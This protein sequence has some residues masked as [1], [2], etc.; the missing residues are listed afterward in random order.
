MPLRDEIFARLEQV[1]F[2]GFRYGIVR[3]GL[4]RDVRVEAG[5]VV[6]ELIAASRRREVAQAIAQRVQEAVATIPQVRSVRVA[7]AGDAAP[8][9]H[10]HAEGRADVPGVRRILAVSS[11]KGG[12]GKSTVAVNLAVSLRQAGAKVALMDADVYGPSAPL[13][14]GIDARPRPVGGKIAPIERYGIDVMSM[15]FFLDDSSPVIWRGPMV[16][17]LI[18]QFLRDIEWGEQDYLVVDMP[19]GTGDAA[20]TLA[21]QVPLAGAV[22]VTTPQEVALADVERGIAMFRQLHVPVLGLV[23]NM[24]Y[25]ECPDCG[26]REE[27]FG[28]G[29]ADSLARQFGVDVLARLPL[30]TEVRESG[31]AGRPITI[32][33]PDHAV[34]KSF[35]ELA[36]LLDQALAGAV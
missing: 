3:Y 13:L 36:R 12:V 19:P 32:A 28:A 16:M 22:I 25:Y 1:A 34:S 11:A 8:P 2:P 33:A 27:M 6:V 23:E 10:A 24:S 30:M 29:G 7:T 15:G 9:P 20:L 14:F 31:D 18:R 26:E 4:V 35:A 17:G 5:E 21:Q